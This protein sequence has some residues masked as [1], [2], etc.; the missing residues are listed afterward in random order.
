M[1]RRTGDIYTSEEGAYP[2]QEWRESPASPAGNVR[3]SSAFSGRRRRTWQRPITL[4]PSA[5][6]VRAGVARS[7]KEATWTSWSSSPEVPGIFG[8]IRL[9]RYLSELLGQTSGPG[10]KGRA[11]TPYRPPHPE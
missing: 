3:G 1:C 2:D 5:S 4:D 9:E 7:T 11:Q 6:S 8:F 10:R